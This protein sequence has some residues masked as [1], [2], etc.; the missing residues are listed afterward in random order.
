MGLSL[1]EAE[2]RLR[3]WFNVS[4]QV[5]RRERCGAL[6]TLG[7]KGPTQ[8][9]DEGNDLLAGPLCCVVFCWVNV[10]YAD[11]GFQHHRFTQK[12]AIV[13][14]WCV[15]CVLTEGSKVLK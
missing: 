1:H 8:D 2:G 7:D 15:Q 9:V 5:E 6:V 12:K 4:P 14:R 11:P 13:A 10:K 3:F